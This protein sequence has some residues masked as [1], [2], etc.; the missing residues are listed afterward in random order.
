M[1]ESFRRNYCLLW[2][3]LIHRDDDKLKQASE[4]LGVGCFYKLFPLIFTFRHI[5]SSRSAFTDTSMSKL[6][7]DEIRKD[8]QDSSIADANKFL[9]SLPKDMLL[10]FRT[11]ALIR[12]LNFDLGGSTSS[13]LK[14]MF[15]Y[16]IRGSHIRNES[17]FIAGHTR[18]SI[19]IRHQLCGI[20]QRLLLWFELLQLRVTMSFASL[21]VQVHSWWSKNSSQAAKLNPNT[22]FG[23]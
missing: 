10:I 20:S 18:L 6:E 21:L 14:I 2:K 13:R 11:N 1:D 23:G 3:S 8:F 7:R 4:N 15:E 22:P 5:G 12:S 19:P 9:Q 16:A 17:D